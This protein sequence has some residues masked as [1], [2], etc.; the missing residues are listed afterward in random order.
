MIL[1]TEVCSGTGGKLHLQSWNHYGPRIAGVVRIGDCNQ[2]GEQCS[3]SASGSN[4][5]DKR[6]SK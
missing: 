1:S 4:L 6:T 5:T 2:S 3:V